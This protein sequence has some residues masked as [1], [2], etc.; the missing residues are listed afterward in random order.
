MKN[1]DFIDVTSL[2]SSKNQNFEGRFRFHHHGDN[3]QLLGTT[4]ADSFHPD[5]NGDTF[6]RN[7]GTYKSP[8]A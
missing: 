2:G 8:T 4:V 5:I 3:N 6:L 1:A 7:V